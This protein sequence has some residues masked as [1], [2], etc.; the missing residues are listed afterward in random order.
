MR[1]TKPFAA[2]GINQR[3]ARTRGGNSRPLF[4]QKIDL[5][6]M[7]LKKQ[8]MKEMKMIKLDGRPDFLAAKIEEEHMQLL[9][10][11]SRRFGLEKA[12]EMNALA[13]SRVSEELAELGPTL[14]KLGQ[15]IR[16]TDRAARMLVAVK[17]KGARITAIGRNVKLLIAKK[18]LG[19]HVHSTGCASTEWHGNVRVTTRD[20]KEEG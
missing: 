15:A 6:A 10:E 20:A 9:D 16:A 1:S 7:P 13:A 18:R 19:N 5:G 12:L 2:S 3:T 14:D 11:L 17:S 8:T 4:V